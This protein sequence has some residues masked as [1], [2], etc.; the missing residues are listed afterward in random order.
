MRSASMQPREENSCEN[1]KDSTSTDLSHCTFCITITVWYCSSVSV[2]S[3]SL[4]LCKCQVTDNL[5]SPHVTLITSFQCALLLF[6]ALLSMGASFLQLH[7][8]NPSSKW[9][10]SLYS[11]GKET[12]KRKVLLLK[13]CNYIA[14]RL[15]PKWVHLCWLTGKIVLGLFHLAF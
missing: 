13:V 3:N 11:R 5:K 1:M 4:A 10:R 15:P 6:S 8:L 9:L 12:A 14:K 2:T 7:F